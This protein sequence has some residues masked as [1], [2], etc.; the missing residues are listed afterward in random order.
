MNDVHSLQARVA[1]QQT[2]ESQLRWVNLLPGNAPAAMGSL[3]QQ[4]HHLLD[5]ASRLAA[6]ATRYPL[7]SVA[8]GFA[9]SIIASFGR[10]RQSNR[11][12]GKREIQGAAVTIHALRHSPQRMRRIF[13]I[14][15]FFK[16][17]FAAPKS[18]WG[19]V[20]RGKAA[21]VNDY[22]ALG[23]LLRHNSRTNC[24]LGLVRR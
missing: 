7:R 11:S 4:F 13:P 1:G 23:T 8:C 22:R 14:G 20:K 18:L 16:V 15:N 9:P 21:L 3:V 10:R 19:A 17:A 5:A 24:V 6:A 12:M 2:P